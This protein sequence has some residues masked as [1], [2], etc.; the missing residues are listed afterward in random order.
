MGQAGSFEK[1]RG[2]MSRL[3]FPVILV[4]AL[5]RAGSSAAVHFVDLNS[6]NPL[7]PY[8]SWGTAATAIQD[9]VDV[10]IPGDVILVTNGVYETGGKVAYGVTTNRVAVTQPVTL[11]SVNGATAT[12]IQGYPVL[13]N[14][15]VR[16]VYLT[17]GCTLIGF[18]LRNGATVTNSMLLQDMRGAGVLCESV[19][20]VVSNCI[21]T[22]NAA[23][24]SGGAVCS[25]TLCNCRIQGNSSSWGEALT[26]AP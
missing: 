14:S 21:L 1:L 12:I 25:G 10:A 5:Q 23:A 7:P 13:G 16:C 8:T 19:T 20:A 3:F 17:N 6:I 24:D 4:L 9:A 18:T 26:R 2:T 22:A 11:Q 15:A